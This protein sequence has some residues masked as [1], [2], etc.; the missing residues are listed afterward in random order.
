[1]QAAEYDL[2]AQVEE[3]HWWFQARLSVVRSVLK[4]YVPPGR[5]LDCSCGTGMTLR[6]LPQY[7]QIGADLAAPALMHCRASG[8]K[9]VMQASLTRLP[10]ADAALDLVT[11]LDTLEHI[12]DDAAALAEVFRVLK[13]GGHALFTVPAHPFLFSGHDRALH[14]VRRYRKIELMRRVDE[15]GFLVDRAS[16][17][18][19]ALFPLVALVRKLRPDKGE[20]H[21]DTEKVPFGPVNW[22]LYLSFALER[23]PLA[24]M[25]LPWG[26]SLLCLARKPQ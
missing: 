13:P 3:R 19:C 1:M 17:I 12:E 6:R 18:N 4:R 10:V 23:F 15:A 2:M 22:A 7:V 11:C 21:S 20:T 26:V 25:D 14:H 8:L 24:V 16:Y 5:G 9:T